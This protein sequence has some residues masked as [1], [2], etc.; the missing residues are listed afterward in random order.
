MVD[1]EPALAPVIPPVT[2]PT[3]HVKL[4]GVLEVKAIF[5][6]DPLQ[7]VTAEVL[8]TEGTRLTVTV[9]TKGAPIHVPPETVGVT[10]YCTVPAATLLGLVN[11]WLI[12]VPVPELAPVIPP[13]IVPTDQA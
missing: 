12:T 5:G 10:I 1:P 6:L 7:A 8:V 11:T 13:V 3:V 2:V 9:I 4:L